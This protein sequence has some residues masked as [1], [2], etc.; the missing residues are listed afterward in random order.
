MKRICQSFNYKKFYQY[1]Q[2]YKWLYNEIS[3]LSKSCI[4]NKD[5]K[6]CH[7]KRK[8][9]DELF[10][11]KEDEEFIKNAFKEFIENNEKEERKEN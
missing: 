9:D 5:N 7:L 1:S 3:D 2:Y 8:N 6:F 4:I 10:L 11:T